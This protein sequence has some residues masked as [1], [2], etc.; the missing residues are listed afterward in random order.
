MV[1]KKAKCTINA[2]VITVTY[3]ADM[4]KQVEL[5]SIDHWISGSKC[6]WATEHKTASPKQSLDV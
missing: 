3:M 2:A 6:L 1:D 4:T 5:I